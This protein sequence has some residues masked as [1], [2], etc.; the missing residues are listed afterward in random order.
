MPGPWIEWL[1]PPRSRASARWRSSSRLRLLR[2]PAG[3]HEP[4]QYRNHRPPDR[5]R[6]H[7]RAGDDDHHYLRRDRP[8]GRL[9]HRALH[10]RLLAARL[11]LQMG[12][13]PIFARARRA[14]RPPRVCGVVNGGLLIPRLKVVRPSSSAAGHVAGRARRRQGVGKRAENRRA[15]HVAQ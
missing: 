7:G 11:L 13:N 6:R 4:P 5:D 15:A 3:F 10:R 8:L 2:A 9:D 1:M 14:S 12:A